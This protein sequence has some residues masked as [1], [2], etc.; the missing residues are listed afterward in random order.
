MSI[1]KDDDGV[2]RLWWVGALALCLTACGA[3]KDEAGAGSACSVVPRTD[4]AFPAAL[5][6]QL[7][8]VLDA[9]LEDAHAPGVAATVVIPGVG[10]WYGAAG[11]ANGITEEPMNAGARFRIGSITKTFTAAA[12]LQEVEAGRASLDDPID[13]FAPGWSFGPDVTIAR[14]MSHT[15]G[16]YN[17]TDDP[18]FLSKALV[19]TPPEQI[20]D[21]AVGHGPVAPPGTLYSYSNTDYF[22]IGLALEKIEGRSY[23][24][25]I[26]D[27]L[28][29]PIGLP[30][31]YFEQVED[32][33]CAPV[34]GH[35]N[36]SLAPEDFSMSWA[37]AAGGLVSSVRD[38]CVWADHLTRG[39]V[40]DD[41]T[42]ARMRQFD[43]L[44]KD[45]DRYGL[46]I[47]WLTRGGRD[48]LG[49]TGSTMGFNGELWID[50]D[51]GVCVA[52]Q[53]NDFL[54]VH[55]AVGEPLWDT[56]QGA[57]Y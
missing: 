54:G 7:D 11:Y 22:L 53:T 31:T 15:A 14:V 34:K 6:A 57:G 51:S 45:S 56:L 12:M 48:V 21:F 52:A 55:K 32:G 5:A 43:P 2:A 27:R 37:W 25:I 50:P 49:H 46:G 13:K 4:A 20:V 35:V 16:V 26:R 40:L 30:D 28:I 39:A 9:T 44:S 42:R 19:Y 29:D 17:Y 33:H 23:E 8:A 1:A 18:V 24:S 10:A 38:L 41:A 36:G 47:R 3:S